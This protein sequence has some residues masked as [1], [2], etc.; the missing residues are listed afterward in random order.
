MVAFGYVA[1]MAVLLVAAPGIYGKIVTVGIIAGPAAFTFR[2]TRLGAHFR[3]SDLLL[4]RTFRTI[5]IPWN[6][7]TRFVVAPRGLQPLCVFANLDDG[8]RVWIEGIGPWF[9]FAKTS[10]ELTRL[11]REMNVERERFQQMASP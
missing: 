5:R 8:S 6:R 4:V 1:L 7:V 9:R 10:P 11:V 3:S 2:L